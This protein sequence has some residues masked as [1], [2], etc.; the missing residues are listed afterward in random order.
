MYNARNT[1]T[2]TLPSLCASGYTT[3][4]Q[5]SLCEQDTNT[6]AFISIGRDSPA[7]L[8]GVAGTIIV[9]CPLK[10]LQKDQETY[11]HIEQCG[12]ICIC[13]HRARSPTASSA[14]NC[15]QRR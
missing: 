15:D 3:A 4:S 5:I 8:A 1:S 7:E 12:H 6:C 10:A 11:W 13:C 14:C 9:I 2:V